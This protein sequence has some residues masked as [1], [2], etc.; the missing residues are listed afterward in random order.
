MEREYGH[1]AQQIPQT[2]V[3]KI[4]LLNY[5]ILQ[6]ALYDVIEKVM[7]RD[8]NIHFYL[9]DIVRCKLLNYYIVQTVITQHL[10]K[11]I[12]PKKKV[13][14]DNNRTNTD[15]KLL[16]SIALQS[17]TLRQKRRYSFSLSEKKELKRTFILPSTP[18]SIRQ[19]TKRNTFFL[20]ENILV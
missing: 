7:S 11:L 3:L 1:L 14:N 2:D 18:L 15:C 5:P 6:N 8:T 19:Q 13:S 17:K 20:A 12:V 16:I 10:Q 9:I 4:L